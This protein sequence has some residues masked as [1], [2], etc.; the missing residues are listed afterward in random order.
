MPCEVLLRRQDKLYNVTC[1]TDMP[2]TAHSL[3]AETASPCLPPT[4]SEGKVA[5]TL[6]P[7]AALLTP[8][9]EALHFLLPQCI[10]HYPERCLLSS[11]LK[12]I[13]IF[14]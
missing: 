2:D 9:L 7:V 4:G 11:D 5:A 12:V 3:E 10:I 14:F 8:T 1:F 13:F 6:L